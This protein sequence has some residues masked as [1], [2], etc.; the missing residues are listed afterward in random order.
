MG[1]S[2]KSNLNKETLRDL[3]RTPH[4][5]QKALRNYQKLTDEEVIARFQEGDLVAYD[6]IVARYKNQL[7]HF[8]MT[9]VGERSDAEDI[10][11]DTFVKIYRFKQ[12]YRNIARFS[13]W[14]Y[15]VAGNLARSELRKKKRRQ[16]FSISSLG[17]GTKDF[18]AVETRSTADEMADHSFKKALVKKAIRELPE[19]YQKVIR[20][21]EIEHLSYE[22]IAKETGLPIGTVRSRINRARTK[23]Q[24][25]LKDVM[26]R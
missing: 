16:Q 17:N 19:R 11:Q 5:V 2:P 4:L 26:D 18:E 9:F 15:T 23:L 7:T 3:V 14:I 1:E 22:E 21:R 12:L 20:L 24:A 10:V 8:V 13:T 25:K 6:V